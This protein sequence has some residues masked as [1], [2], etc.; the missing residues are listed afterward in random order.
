MKKMMSLPRFFCIPEKVPNI[1][2]L[3]HWF[4]HLFTHSLIVLLLS[5]YKPIF[6]SFIHGAYLY[7]FISLLNY[8]RKTIPTMKKIIAIF[9]TVAKYISVFVDFILLLLCRI[10]CFFFPEEEKTGEKC[11]SISFFLGLRLRS[12]SCSM[13]LPWYHNDGG[14]GNDERIN[15]ASKAITQFHGGFDCRTTCAIEKSFH[16]LY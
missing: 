6:A 4:T 12:D 8:K 13:R 7:S 11:R 5:R 16:S 14:S 3:T 9:F 2:S 15:D 1:L 10:N